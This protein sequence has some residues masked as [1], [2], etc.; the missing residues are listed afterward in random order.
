MRVLQLTGPK[1]LAWYEAPAPSLASDAA[2]IV[3]PIAAASCDLDWPLVAGDVPFPY[4]V[5]LGHEFVGI[6]TDIG[7]EVRRVDVGDRVA[8]AFQPSC[9]N[10]APCRRGTTS[11]CTSVPKISM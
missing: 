7:D 8:V 5:T 1:Q 4:P 2:A 10:C 6:A 3:R 11:A 9:G